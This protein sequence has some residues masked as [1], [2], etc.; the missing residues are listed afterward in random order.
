MWRIRSFAVVTGGVVMAMSI[1]VMVAGRAG[2][3]GVHHG[4]AQRPGH[5]L[6]QRLQRRRA[7][8]AAQIPQWPGKIV[9]G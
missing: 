9:M 3:H 6:E 1:A 4:H 8:P 7:E 5:H 2:L